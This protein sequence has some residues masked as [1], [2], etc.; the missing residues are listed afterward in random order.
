MGFLGF[1]I[2]QNRDVIAP[3]LI[4]PYKAWSNF[5]GAL[6]SEGKILTYYIPALSTDHI[7]LQKHILLF[8]N[9][10]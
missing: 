7:G 10:I 1:L 4:R 9:N 6:T 2:E 8:P 5:W 3:F